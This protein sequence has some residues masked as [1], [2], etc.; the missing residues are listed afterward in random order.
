MDVLNL[1]Y[2]EERIGAVLQSL[3]VPL[4]EMSLIPFTD[5]QTLI[6]DLHGNVQGFVTENVHGGI[7]VTDENMNIIGT[8]HEQGENSLVFDSEMDQVGTIQDNVFGGTNLFNDEGELQLVSFENMFFG[9]D[10]YDSEMQYVG[11]SSEV[12]EQKLFSMEEIDS[13]NI[14]VTSDILN[15]SDMIQDVPLELDSLDIL[16]LDSGEIFDIFDLFW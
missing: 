5:G 3:Q 16:L 7:D 6:A 15:F 1:M 9:E 10:Y 8:V 14:D 4:D 11:S 13:P 2:P 12:N